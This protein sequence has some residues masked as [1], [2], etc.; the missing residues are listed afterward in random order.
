M[1]K[2]GLVVD[3]TADLDPTYYSERDVVM[4]PLTV[5]FGQ[6][7]YLDWT[8]M[9]PNEFYKR[10]TASDELPKTSQPSVNQFVEA[11][12]E[13]G[14]RCE[15]IVSMHLSS[16]LSGTIQSAEVA[17]QQ[18]DTPVTVIDTK[19]ASLGVALALDD[20]VRLRDAGASHDDLV[21]QVRSRCASISTLF[22]VDTLRYLQMG[23]RIGKASALVGTL[24][25]I[26]PILK[27]GEDGVVAPYKKVKGAERV[28]AEL[29]SAVKARVDDEG[30]IARVS[31]VHAAQP[32]AVA[33][34]KNALAVGE[35]PFEAVFESSI[36]SVIGT[37][38]GPG[39][40]G[41]IFY[42]EATP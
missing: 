9:R 23:G 19:L 26:R 36:G 28:C 33:R 41:V 30:G 12:R 10:L 37:Y 27:L 24:L 8:E 2:L 21:E 3:S 40:F 31:F 20:A 14:D 25:K 32:D 35:V 22:Y 18:V 39:A 1:V 13:L 16:Q 4:V 6:E 15:Q 7:A 17:A 5:R 38:V 34:L 11:Y 42:V 29:V